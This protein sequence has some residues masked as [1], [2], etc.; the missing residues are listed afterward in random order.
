MLLL[1]E[2]RVIFKPLLMTNSLE[3]E[4]PEID[5]LVNTILVG[6]IAHFFEEIFLDF[7]RVNLLLF[8]TNQFLIDPKKLMK[9]A[10]GLDKF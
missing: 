10:R 8:T 9:A 5:K 2:I 4:I 7:I 3:T 6:F 1:V